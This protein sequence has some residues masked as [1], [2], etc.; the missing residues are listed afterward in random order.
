VTDVLC[1]LAVTVV[2]LASTMWLGRCLQGDAPPSWASQRLVHA[3]LQ[4]GSRISTPK[5]P[6]E[7]T[8]LPSSMAWF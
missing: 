2:F 4:A 8:A 6:P 3:E 5:A 7:L 1:K